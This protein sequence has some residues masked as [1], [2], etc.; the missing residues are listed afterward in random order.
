MS[1]VMS[2]F[3]LSFMAERSWTEIVRLHRRI[4]QPKLCSRSA[5]RRFARQRPPLGRRA[6]IVFV[7]G[8]LNPFQLLDQGGTLRTGRP[9]GA[10]LIA[11]AGVLFAWRHGCCPC[12]TTKA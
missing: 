3:L 1:E 12:T 4:D 5:A 9:A 8:A 6:M 2:K 11:F 10:D 7:E